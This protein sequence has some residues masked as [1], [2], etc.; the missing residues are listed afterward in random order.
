[1]L[2][3][4][5]SLQPSFTMIFQAF[6]VVISVADMQAITFPLLRQ[7]QTDWRRQTCCKDSMP[8]APQRTEVKEPHIITTRHPIGTKV[9]EISC[10][11]HTRNG[12]AY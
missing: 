9:K 12:I 8:K 5:L 11:L 10:P 6:N 3:V 4:T 7:F 1:M 2:Q